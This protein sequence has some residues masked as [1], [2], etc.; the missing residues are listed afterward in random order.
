M[1]KKQLA[2]KLGED[3]EAAGGDLSDK[4][5]AF[6]DTLA[7]SFEVVLA[8]AKRYNKVIDMV[9]SHVSKPLKELSQLMLIKPPE[10]DNMNVRGAGDVEEALD[11]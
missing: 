2:E 4:I 1:N 9:N 8:A 11:G 3:L 10:L 6:N 7:E 5:D